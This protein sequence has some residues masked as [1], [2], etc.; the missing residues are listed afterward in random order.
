MYCRYCGAEL[1]PNA[2]VCMKCGRLQGQY[3]KLPTEYFKRI[4][5]FIMNILNR[6]PHLIATIIGSI[7]TILTI[8]WFSIQP[9]FVMLW[10]FYFLLD[11]KNFEWHMHPSPF[12]F[13]LIAMSFNGACILIIILIILKIILKFGDLGKTLLNFLFFPLIFFWTGLMEVYFVW[14]RYYN[15]QFSIFEIVVGI[16]GILITLVSSYKIYQA[17]TDKGPI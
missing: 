14:F 4:K 12:L 2:D 8:I 3:F 15:R 11:I 5:N 16:T 6:L 17:L 13:S 7:I 1:P 9:V 10:T